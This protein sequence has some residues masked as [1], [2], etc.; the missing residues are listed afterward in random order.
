MSLRGRVS[1]IKKHLFR[2]KESLS[3]FDPW[4]FTGQGKRYIERVQNDLDKDIGLLD[5]IKGE[6]VDDSSPEDG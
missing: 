3:S 4:D 6:I 1:R 5:D 2:A